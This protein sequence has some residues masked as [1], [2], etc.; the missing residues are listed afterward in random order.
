MPKTTET[1]IQ[2][3][4]IEGTHETRID[5]IFEVRAR[6][7]VPP[8][9][10]IL[11]GPDIKLSFQGYV[12]ENGYIHLNSALVPKYVQH[13]FPLNI[14]PDS[15]DNPNLVHQVHI[16]TIILED[17]RVFSLYVS[18]AWNL[19]N[20]LEKEYQDKYLRIDT[21]FDFEAMWTRVGQQH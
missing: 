6:L 12:N 1:I 17:G 20:L 2:R 16:R 21:P 4:I 14:K 7:P 13:R 15:D 8:T 19:E 9:A 18:G 11:D 5:R 3:G 10:S